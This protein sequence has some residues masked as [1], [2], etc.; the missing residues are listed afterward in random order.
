M[1]TPTHSID[2]TTDE[3]VQLCDAVVRS[4]GDFE[5]AAKA[6]NYA[7]TA[8]ECAAR[9]AIVKRRGQW[10]RA[11]DDYLREL[12]TGDAQPV[13]G[14]SPQWVS[15]AQ[16]IPGRTGKQ[17][18]E[19]Y[20]NHLAPGI[21]KQAWTAE[22]DAKLV[23]LQQ[24]HGNSW[25]R[26]ARELPG[27]AEN[28]VKNRWNGMFNKRVGALVAAQQGQARRRPAGQ[29]QGTGMSRRH[30]STAID[31]GAAAAIKRGR[32]GNGNGSGSGSGSGAPEF[33]I[34][35]PE[36]GL[37]DALAE[38]TN[39]RRAARRAS[40]S[41]ARQQG[42]GNGNGMHAASLDACEMSFEDLSIDAGGLGEH[43]D[44]LQLLSLSNLST[45]NLS[46]STDDTAQTSMPLLATN[47]NAVPLGAPMLMPTLPP[48]PSPAPAPTPS[49]AFGFGRRSQPQPQS[50]PQP[51]A[52][53]AAQHQKPVTPACAHA[54]DVLDDPPTTPPQGQSQM[55]MPT[56]TQCSPTGHTG[57]G[58]DEARAR[59][60]RR[61][62]E[63]C[64]SGTKRKLGRK[65]APLPLRVPQLPQLENSSLY[66]G[67][68]GGD[69]AERAERSRRR[70]GT[71]S[72]LQSA[73]H[74]M[75]GGG[76]CQPHAASF[77][78]LMSPP[79]KRRLCPTLQSLTPLSPC[80]SPGAAL[81]LQDN[82]W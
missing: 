5:H 18:R 2:W 10:T 6:L 77:S 53:S 49:H 3:D 4:R 61:A 34:G 79:A 51:F 46:W 17:C 60:R 22:E 31:G 24:V 32:D 19:R 25:C 26:I 69:C 29:M 81:S 65:P 63:S 1:D 7:R 36:D 41:V 62:A 59:I 70:D 33:G 78:S 27:R 75:I 82:W 58:A 48:M 50:Q 71:S 80:P 44:S 37:L 13:E 11:E 76:S 15:I 16:L 45:D 66:V 56:P 72:T 43:S 14:G 30:S 39:E 35:E 67:R 40:H 38:V 74:G 28:A 20:K 12:V 54:A 55:Q 23:A 8:E 52:R 68:L 64:V 42:N 9:A 57:N 21:C 73:A 47:V